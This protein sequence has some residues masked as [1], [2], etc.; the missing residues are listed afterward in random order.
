MAKKKKQP[1]S[2]PYQK[3]KEEEKDFIP[4]CIVLVGISGCGK[5]TFAKNLQE[6]F[7]DQNGK[8]YII[9]SSDNIRKELTGDMNNQEHNEEVFTLLHRRL[10]EQ[11]RLKNSVIIDATNLKLKNR[12]A[13]LNCIKKIP[14]FK[15]VFI[16]SV[17]RRT[18]EEN[19]LKRDRKVPCEVLKRQE[20]SFEIPFYEEGW[21][22]IFFVDSE[23][24]IIK[25]LTDIKKINSL[26]ESKIFREQVGFN[27]RTKHH[28]YTLDEHSE[29][30]ARAIETYKTP[31][32]ILE[33]QRMFDLDKNTVQL[34]LYTIELLQ[35]VAYIHDYGKMFV[36]IPKDDGSGDYKYFNHHNVSAYE[37]MLNM[38]QLGLTNIDFILDFL[39]YVNYHMQPFFINTPKAEKKWKEIFGD[40][41]FNM[42]TIFNKCDIIGSGTRKERVGVN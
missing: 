5:S 14:C 26:K 9:L 22:K 4:E 36:G 40:W 27:Q 2:I 16:F 1:N 25:G 37:I 31:S 38:N 18:C 21:D 3:P 32:K 15:T 41:K 28:L 35:Q 20:M 39:F 11:L 33:A 30:V 6:N 29:R 23:G 13:Y 10:K 7:T 24:N 17:P 42:L 12:R 19:Q 34:Y 8:P